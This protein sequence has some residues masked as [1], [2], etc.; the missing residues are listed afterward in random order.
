[1][2]D[3]G[4]ERPDYLPLLT[5]IRGIAALWVVFFHLPAYFRL[6]SI[7]EYLQGLEEG[8]LAC[9]L[10]FVLSG[11][12][13]SHVY[14]A[15]FDHKVE[16]KT[17]I[18]FMYARLSRIYPLHAF[19]LLLFVLLEVVKWT[20]LYVAGLNIA[21]QEQPF[22]GT[23]SPSSL[24]AQLLLLNGWGIS[25]QH[26]WN[27][28]SW[29]I[30]T[31][32]WVYAVFPFLILAMRRFSV[33]SR[34]VLSILCLGGLYILESLHGDL[35]LNLTGGAAMFRCLFEFA[36]G[37]LVYTAYKGRTRRLNRWTTPALVLSPLAVAAVI[38]AGLPDTCVVLA[39]C[40]TVLSAA[41]QGPGRLTTL[42]GSR[43]M[44]FLGE[45]SYSVY[46]MQIFV[47]ELLRKV[48]AV[49]LQGMALGPGSPSVVWE[50]LFAAG[51]VAAVIGA[52]TLTYRYVERPVQSV[53]RRL[54]AKP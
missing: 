34:G 29:S 50:T 44:T 23:R 51:T 42:L 26:S 25:G 16:F 32:W 21:A 18:R 30:S 27:F 49:L 3:R 40:V 45:I 5:P 38:F 54:I 39:A 35:R 47:F 12:V 53:L 4:P 24:A 7:R 46:L 52:S 11:F 31:E 15:S 33:R 28:P 20:L 1:M 36:L 37:M 41:L 22:A 9:D 14:T 2:R 10:F 8:Y 19:V 17:Y 48:S 13:L 6:P 43:C